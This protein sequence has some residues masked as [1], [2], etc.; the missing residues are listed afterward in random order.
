MA[1]AFRQDE[2]VVDGSREAIAFVA[3]DEEKLVLCRVSFEALCDADR[4][5]TTNQSAML[6]QYHRHVIDIR[7]AAQRSYDT[8][9]LVD[10]AVLVT[11]RDLLGKLF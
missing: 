10:G 7:A 5:G 8:G 1:L 9:K 3:Y 4:L 6:Q 11:S 2:F